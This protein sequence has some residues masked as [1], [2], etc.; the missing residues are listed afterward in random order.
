MTERT[1][2]FACQSCGGWTIVTSSRPYPNGIKRRRQC[3]DCGVKFTT[4][5]TL[6]DDR[7]VE[8]ERLL[9]EMREERS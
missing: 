5:E 9:R 2:S 1:G 4:Y 7:L 6:G 3:R 8:I